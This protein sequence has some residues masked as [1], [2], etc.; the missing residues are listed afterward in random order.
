MFQAVSN[1]TEIGF[2]IAI[3]GK[4][5]SKFVL[6]V[7]AEIEFGFVVGT[8][9]ISVDLFADYLIRNGEF[10]LSFIRSANGE[11]TEIVEQAHKV[12]GVG[13]IDGRKTFFQFS[14]DVAFAHQCLYDGG[15]MSKLFVLP[16][17]HT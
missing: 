2:P 11:H 1:I 3:V 14:G 15:I 17:E 9:Q 12:V 13:D 7:T 5:A 16:D 6:F 8:Q 4:S 10:G